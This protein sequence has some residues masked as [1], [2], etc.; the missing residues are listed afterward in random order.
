MAWL[1]E[2]RGYKNVVIAALSSLL[3]AVTCER[4]EQH[5]PAG[6][7]FRWLSGH[8]GADLMPFVLPDPISGEFILLATNLNAEGPAVE[9]EISRAIVSL[10][11]GDSLLGSMPLVTEWDG[12]LQPSSQDTVRLLKLEGDSVLFGPVCDRAVLIDV[13]V[14]RL[15]AEP[16]LVRSGALPFQCVY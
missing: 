10:A 11:E 7:T 14:D 1:H 5:A 9:V 8:I 3:L 15:D 2:P 16:V 12:L 4:T 6:I 13:L